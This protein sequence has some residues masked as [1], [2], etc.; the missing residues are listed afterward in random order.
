MYQY[1]ITAPLGRP[2]MNTTNQLRFAPIIRV[3]TEKQAA[4]GESLRTQKKQIESYVQQLGGNI[5]HHC[6]QFSGQEHATPEQERQKLKKLLEDSDKD[7]FDAVI[8]CD[9]SRWSRDNEMN[10]RGLRILKQNDI[11][12]FVGS[13]EYDLYSPDQTLFL[14]MAVEIGEFQAAQ[15]TQKSLLNKIERAKRGIPTSGKL[16][17]GRIY[18]HNTNSWEIDREKRRKL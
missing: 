3:S 4:K 16:P 7:L 11:K 8:V 5:P 1:I 17:Y 13:T 18:N 15:Q 10:K 14:S 9:A 6:W 12:F 2:K